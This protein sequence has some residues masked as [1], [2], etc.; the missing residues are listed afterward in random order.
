MIEKRSSNVNTIKFPSMILLF[1]KLA[2]YGLSRSTFIIACRFLSF[3]VFLFWLI[4]EPVCKVSRSQ[5]VAFRIS[6]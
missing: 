3:R 6:V 5:R 1:V 4:L 2:V